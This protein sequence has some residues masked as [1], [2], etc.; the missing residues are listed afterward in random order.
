MPLQ[1]GPKQFG[2]DG[3]ATWER[4]RTHRVSLHVKHCVCQGDAGKLPTHPGWN[5]PECGT[6]DVPQTQKAQIRAT[7]SVL[8]KAW[9]LSFLL[10]PVLGRDDIVTG[11]PQER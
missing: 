8:R 3:K 4:T 1:Q 6:A 2:H 5:D 7:T 9:S 10:L 11:K